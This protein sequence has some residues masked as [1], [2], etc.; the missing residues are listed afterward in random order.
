VFLLLAHTAYIEERALALYFM[1]VFVLFFHVVPPLIFI[2]SS[3]SRRCGIT[4]ANKVRSLLSGKLYVQ[5]TQQQQQRITQPDCAILLAQA[6]KGSAF[7]AVAHLTPLLAGQAVELAIPL[8]VI[9]QRDL[10]GA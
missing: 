10:L 3:Y 7:P 2:V 4:L 1:S 5:P 9:I 6:S 8:C